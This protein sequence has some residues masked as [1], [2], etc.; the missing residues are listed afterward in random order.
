MSA[1]NQPA[2]PAREADSNKATESA[3]WEELETQKR[4]CLEK[5]KEIEAQLAEVNERFPKL[6]EELERLMRAAEVLGNHREELCELTGSKNERA[7]GQP[8]SSEDS[9][10]DSPEDSHVESP[11]ASPNMES[12]E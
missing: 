2:S 9:S 3:I 5:E 7:E 8:D 6:R 12:E 4:V 10:E 11:M 1:Q